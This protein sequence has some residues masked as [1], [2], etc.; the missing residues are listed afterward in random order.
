MTF[1]RYAIGR[2]DLHTLLRAIGVLR[3]SEQLLAVNNADLV[4]IG[5]G[6][7]TILVAADAPATPASSD[8]TA[9]SVEQLDE[10]YRQLAFFELERAAETERLRIELATIQHERERRTQEHEQRDDRIP[11]AVD[12]S[13]DEQI[14]SILAGGGASPEAGGAP[15]EGGAEPPVGGPAPEAPDQD[16]P[17]EPDPT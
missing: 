4:S 15:P 5:G 12:R 11:P 14:R 10:R 17:P 16:I 13:L 7:I 1:I 2:N 8:L 6:D 9:W 3:E